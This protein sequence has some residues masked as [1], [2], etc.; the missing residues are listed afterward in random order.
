MAAGKAIVA[1]A[2]NEAAEV[3]RDGYDGLLVEPGDVNKFAGATLKL[4]DDPKERGRLGQNAREQAV[5][6]YSWE[7]YT[8]RLEEIY[9]RVVGI[10]PSGAPAVDISGNS[11]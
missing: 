1:T 7:H 8:R 4:I 3:I 9:F 2:L 10:A 6:Q 11:Y 5:K